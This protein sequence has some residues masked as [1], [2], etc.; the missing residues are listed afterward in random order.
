M[1]IQVISRTIKILKIPS[2]T[3]MLADA[4][5]VTRK[6][7]RKWLKPIC[8]KIGKRKGNYY[9][10]G[11]VGIIYKLLVPPFKIKEAEKA[12]KKSKADRR[13]YA[14]VHS[15]KIISQMQRGYSFD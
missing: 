10:V 9:S 5:G 8:D 13:R 6:T 3:T 15:G 12:E 7:M 2:T 1:N 4:Y 11:Q 14:K